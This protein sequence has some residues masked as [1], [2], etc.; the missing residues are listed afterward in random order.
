MIAGLYGMVDT[1]AAPG[2][3]PLEVADG[4]LAAGVRV[5]QL[6]MKGAPDAAVRRVL[7]PLAARCAAAGASLVVN[8][9]VDLAAEFGVG[10]HLGQDDGDP[11]QARARLGGALVGWSTHDLEQ[12]ARAAALGV[13]YI[14]FGPVFSGTGKHRSRGDSR[15]PMAARGIDGL[16]AAVRASAVP[17]VA[18]GGIGLAQL[19]AVA[20]TGVAAVAAI[21][22][23][24]G[25]DDVAA[26][27]RAFQAAFQAA[28]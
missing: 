4:L 27:A 23:V 26:A 14:G 7:G 28:A 3:D 20:A 16:A 18:I 1:S 12:V 24:A 13:D 10:V 2:R 9:R 22:A 11:R 21:G 19:P 5:L 25:A 15:T 6:R 8:D 17:V